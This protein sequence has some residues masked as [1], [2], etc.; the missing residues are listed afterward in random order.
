MTRLR[1]TIAAQALDRREVESLLPTL[2]EI[3]ESQLVCQADAIPDEEIRRCAERGELALPRRLRQGEQFTA[4]LDDTAQLTTRVWAWDRRAESALKLELA[5]ERPDLEAAEGTAEVSFRSVEHPGRLEVSARGAL[6]RWTVFGRR[7]VWGEGSA[8]LDWPRWW[9]AV[10]TGADGPPPVTAEVAFT[11]ARATVAITPSRGEPGEWRLEISVTVRGRGIW[12]PLV[13]TALWLARGSIRRRFAEQLDEVARELRDE[14]FGRFPRTPEEL[15]A[16]YLESVLH[17]TEE[18]GEDEGDEEDEGPGG[19][20][21][22]NGAHREAVGEVFLGKG[23]EAQAA[24]PD[25]ATDR[26]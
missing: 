10:T 5:S 20:G 9:E 7:M 15:L 13:G 17:E 16:L 18:D 11:P 4:P 1:H 14:D 8:R 26:P 3:A 6:N 19:R 21:E 24:G 25:R 12:R 23:G 22:E 2:H